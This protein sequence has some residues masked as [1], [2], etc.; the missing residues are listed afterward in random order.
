MKKSKVNSGD[1]KWQKPILGA[2]PGEGTGQARASDNQEDRAQ[3]ETQGLARAA[4]PDLG[5]V[6]AGEAEKGERATSKNF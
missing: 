6:A 3:V 5:Q 4:D 1:L 2:S